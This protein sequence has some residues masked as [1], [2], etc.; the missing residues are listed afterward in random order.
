MRS[1]HKARQDVRRLM[2]DGR[3]MEGKSYTVKEYKCQNDT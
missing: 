3:P 1:A 2:L